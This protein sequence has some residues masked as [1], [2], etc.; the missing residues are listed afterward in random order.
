MKSRD[1]QTFTFPQL[2]WNKNKVD[3]L[4]R[5]RFNPRRRQDLRSQAFYVSEG[6][7]DRRDRPVHSALRSVEHYELTQKTRCLHL[8]NPFN[9]SPIVLGEAR[10]WLKSTEVHGVCDVVMLV[11]CVFKVHSSK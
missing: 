5:H 3:A 9:A 1:R 4:P 8:M 7:I 11:L 2:M 10:N 6:L